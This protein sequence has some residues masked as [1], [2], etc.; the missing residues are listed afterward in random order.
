M[1]F[2]VFLPRNNKAPNGKTNL[3]C[4]LQLMLFSFDV[5][6]RESEGTRM[7]PS[8]IRT[9]AYAAANPR[10]TPRAAVMIYD[11]PVIGTIIAANLRIIFENS[12][13]F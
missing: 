4:Q 3:D 12:G 7:S 1:I 5:Y 10:R 9:R 6:F 2:S 13:F 11:M 8:Y